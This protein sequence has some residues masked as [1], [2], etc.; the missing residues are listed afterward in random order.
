MLQLGQFT[1][2]K[3]IN[4]Q[5]K[6]QENIKDGEKRKEHQETSQ[7]IVEGVVGEDPREQCQVNECGAGCSQERSL[8]EPSSHLGSNHDQVMSKEGDPKQMM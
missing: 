8:P 1:N 3:G 6:D 7:E 5:Q 2:Q 4:C